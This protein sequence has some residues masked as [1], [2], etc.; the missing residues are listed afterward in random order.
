M[1]QDQNERFFDIFYKSRFQEII[2][3][4]LT[5]KAGNLEKIVLWFLL[6]SI[7]SSLLTGSLSFLNISE[8]APLWA[9]ISISGTLLSI[10]SLAQAPGERRFLHFDKAR[11]FQSL[12]LEC[13]NFTGYAVHSNIRTE[14][15]DE[16]AIKLHRKY[17]SLLESLEIKHRE[18]GNNISKTLTNQLNDNLR[19]E[20]FMKAEPEEQPETDG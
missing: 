10:Y 6:I 2:A 4:D 18:Y 16:T 3:L 7:A 1:T 5:R 8:L 15:I 13:E 9:I 20:G 14:N 19:A 12:S 11:A 17:A